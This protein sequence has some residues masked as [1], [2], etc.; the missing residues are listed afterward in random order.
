MLKRRVLAVEKR[1]AGLPRPNVN[2]LRVVAVH[3]GD[4][5]PQAAPG[6]QLLII[7][8]INTRAEDDAKKHAKGG[9]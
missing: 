2:G 8:I 1:L 7:R 4:P 9:R 3:D 6:E 5:E